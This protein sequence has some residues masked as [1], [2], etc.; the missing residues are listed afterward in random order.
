MYPSSRLYDGR[1][2]DLPWLQEAPDPMTQ[3]AWD[4][5]VEVPAETARQLGVT[6]GDLVKLTSPHGS[7]ELP[8]YPTESLHPGAVAVAMGQ[9][10]A[11]PAPTRAAERC[12][13][14]PTGPRASS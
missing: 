14:A 8:A 4:A 11:S 5:W 10:H 12:R 6:R 7:I 13:R 9:G 3:V 2:A 1:G